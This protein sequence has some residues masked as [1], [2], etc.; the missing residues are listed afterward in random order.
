MSEFNTTAFPNQPPPGQDD[1]CNIATCPASRSPYHYEPIL[2]LA[3]IPLVLFV[4]I[5]LGHLF[6]GI[7]H[8]TW[9]FTAGMLIGGILEIIGYFGR[10]MAHHDPFA[11]S[12]FIMEITVLWF[13]PV[14]YCASIYLSL[15]RVVAVYG[16]HIARVRPKWYTRIFITCDLISLI[17]QSNSPYLLPGHPLLIFK[18]SWRRCL[19]VAA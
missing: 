7:K 11:T 18:K 8:R 5:T 12:T 15:G 16:A 6:M 1:S 2:M 17:V 4:I 13:A 10:V 3:V 19:C 14:F 9:G